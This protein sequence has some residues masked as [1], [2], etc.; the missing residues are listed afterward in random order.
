MILLTPRFNTHSSLVLHGGDIFTEAKTVGMLSTVLKAL[1][2]SSD[3]FQKSVLDKNVGRSL[4]LHVILSFLGT[5][6]VIVSIIVAFLLF[7][8]CTSL[9]HIYLRVTTFFNIIIS[10]QQEMKYTI[11]FYS[12]LKL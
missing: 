11:M 5:N 2:I 6:W 1:E 12:E 8:V 3:L 10:R 9:F 7:F 4:F